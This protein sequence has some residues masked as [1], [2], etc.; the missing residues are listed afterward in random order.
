MRERKAHLIAASET[1]G[2]RMLRRSAVAAVL[3]TLPALT[4]A[5]VYIDGIPDCGEWISARKTQTALAFESY[6]I[7]FLNGLA[8]GTNREFWQANGVRLSREAVYIWLD[9]HCQAKPLET[10]PTGIHALFRE[11]S[12]WKP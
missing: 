1:L 4:Q 5:Q 6:T 2:G 12:G 11:R 3:I 7:G 9:N 10:L 8:M